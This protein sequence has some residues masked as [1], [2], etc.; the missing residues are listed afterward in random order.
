MPHEAAQPP[1][2]L[3]RRPNILFAIADDW[4]FGHAGA[5]GAGWVRT[6]AFDRVA[7]DGVLFARAYTPNPKCAPSRAILLTGRHSWQLEEAANH[8]PFFPPKFATWPEAL[9]RHGYTT[10]FTGKGWGPGVA[11]DAEGKP[12]QMTGRPFNRHKRQPPTK[13]I[14]ENDYAANFSEFLATVPKGQPWSFWYGAQEPHRAYEYGSG[15]AKGGRTLAEV[16]R[17]PPYWPDIEVV[18]HDV[19][20][21]AFEV[22]HFD[23]HLGLML[24]ALAKA[25][26]LDETIVIVTSDHGMPFPRV[27]GQVYPFATQ[28]PLA[29]M[30]PKGIAGAGRTVSDFVSFVDLAPTLVEAVGLTWNESGLQPTPGASLLPLLRSRQLRAVPGRDHVLLGKERHDVGRPGDVG[31]PVRAIIQGDTFYMRNYQPDRWPAGNPETGYLN[32]DGGPTKTE[33]LQR[34]RDGRDVRPWSLAFGRRPGEELYDLATDPFC[35]T[36][37]AGDRR[38]AQTLRRLRESM[39]RELRAQGD[40]RMSGRGGVFDRYVYAEERTRN[41]YER[42]LRGEPVVAGWVNPSDFEKTPIKP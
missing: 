23:R 37:L 15:V 36:N 10:G 20:D 11:N 27:K 35:L 34:R 17:V 8:V 5:Y 22:E 30:W 19:L 32:T 40:P 38:Q 26:M 25:G 31:Y 41:F 1:A 3:Q 21:Y 39:E 6:P 28:V 4:S 9:V 2:A 7:R 24:D 33:I 42:F 16:G 18:R 12:R 14:S 29:I 13:Q